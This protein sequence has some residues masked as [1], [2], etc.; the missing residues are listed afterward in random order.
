MRAL[1]SR[2]LCPLATTS[3]SS[4]SGGFAIRRQLLG[5]AA[6]HGENLTGREAHDRLQAI[7]TETLD[8]ELWHALQIEQGTELALPFFDLPS[9]G[10][11]LDR[12]AGGDLATD[13]EDI[14]WDR[15]GEEYDKYWTGGGQAKEAR[16]S[17]NRSVD[18]VQTEVRELKGRLEEIESDAMRLSQ[19]VADATRLATTPT[20]IRQARI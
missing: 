11:A 6:P 5:V 8:K 3:S 15:V 14:L 1:R 13:R 18:E 12:A 2:S 19:L 9:L 4:A 20:R 16:K 7:L 17:S 10:R